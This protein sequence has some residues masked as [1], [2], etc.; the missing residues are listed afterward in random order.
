MEPGARA[1][2]VYSAV[3]DATQAKQRYFVDELNKEILDF[4]GRYAALERKQ[5]LQA[6]LRVVEKYE[7][8]LLALARDYRY[9][10]DRGQMDRYGPALE[11]RARVVLAYDPVI[12]LLRTL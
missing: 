2:L 6:K 9:V 1:S 7:K 4:A 8:L 12:A 3:R 5:V 11:E 10:L